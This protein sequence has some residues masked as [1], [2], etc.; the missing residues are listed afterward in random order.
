MLAMSL[1]VLA[2]SFVP[3]FDLSTSWLRHNS[4]AARRGDASD[5]EQ[6]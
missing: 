4:L 1:F 3:L 2:E 6:Q 5:L